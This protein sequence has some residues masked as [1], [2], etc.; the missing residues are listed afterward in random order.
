MLGSNTN[1][2]VQTF[3]SYG[4]ASGPD[5]EQT[6]GAKP[7]LAIAL[8]LGSLASCTG[9]GS[10]G[11]T[12]VVVHIGKPANYSWPTGSPAGVAPHGES[13]W[14]HSVVRDG[15]AAVC[16]TL[17][18]PGFD[19]VISDVSDAG[20]TMAITCQADRS[21]HRVRVIFVSGSG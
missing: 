16:A 19:Y 4:V 15:G 12:A 8:I 11:P 5:C 14:V 21:K 18:P 1:S 7:T 17:N 6:M 2:V 13:L 9:H 3:P 10:P 20:L